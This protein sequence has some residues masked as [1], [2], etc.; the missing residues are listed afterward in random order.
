MISLLS[1]FCWFSVLFAERWTNAGCLMAN[2]SVGGDSK[3][4]MFVNVS[5]AAADA[6]ESLSS[7]KFAARVQAVELG[8]AT[9]HADNAELAKA[10]KNV[11]MRF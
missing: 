7:L 8:Q 6:Q 10:R 3:T 4:V 2:V 11:R 9:K 1:C 5:P